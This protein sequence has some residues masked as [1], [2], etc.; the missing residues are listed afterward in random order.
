MCI[1]LSLA[2]L[3]EI[4]SS[5][6]W[7]FI[8]FVDG[9]LFWA[10]TFKSDV[11]LLWLFRFCRLLFFFSFYLLLAVLGLFCGVRASYCGVV[12]EHGL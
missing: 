1:G 6:S 10:E 4:F 2:L 8:H 7:L 5:I 12:E 9:F 11:V 3:L